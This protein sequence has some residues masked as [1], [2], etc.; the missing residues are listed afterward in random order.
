MNET[1]EK[2]E[3]WKNNLRAIFYLCRRFRPGKTK[4]VFFLVRRR[5]VAA[6]YDN[7][8]RLSEVYRFLTGL[9]Y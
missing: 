9:V 4:Y 8:R 3:K 1:H 2:E 6:S 7:L 5:L